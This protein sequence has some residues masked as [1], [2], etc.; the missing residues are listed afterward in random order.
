MLIGVGFANAPVHAQHPIPIT[1]PF[2]LL[3]PDQATHVVVRS[4]NWT[5]A[6]TWSGNAVPNNLAKVLIP[7]GM[8]LV[9]DGEIATRVK[10]LR[11]QGKLAFSTTSNT[12]LRVETILQDVSGELEIGTAMNP[13]PQGITA[14]ITIIDEGDIDFSTDQ[15]EKGMIL[16]GK[17]VAYGA[18]KDSWVAVAANPTMGTTTLSLKSAPSGWEVGDRIV[19]TGTDPRDAKSDEVGVI[20]AVS[21]T[22][23]TL[24]EPLTKNHTAP[25]A[26]LFVHVANLNRNIVIQSE[27]PTSNGGMDRG[28]VMFM[29]T[30]DVDVNY[31]RFSQMGRSRK[32]RPINDWVIGD[33]AEG[34]EYRNGARTNIRGRYSVHFHRG[35]VDQRLTPAKVTGCVVEDDP[36]WAYVNHSAYVHFDNNVSYNVIGGGFQTEAGNEIGSFTNNIAIRTVNDAYPLRLE[37]PDNAPDTREVSQDFAWQGD[38]FWIH[39]GT[40]TVSGNV[41][42]GSS[43]HGFIYWPEGLIEP[44]G[45]HTEPFRTTYVPQDIGLDNSINVIDEEDALQIWW[46]EVENFSNNIAYSAGIGLS[47]YYL[48]TTFF[49]D[50]R[51]YDPAYIASVHSTFQDFTAWNIDQQGIQ[52]NFT[53][54]VTFKNIRL[55]NGGEDANSIGIRA[56]QYR[57]KTRH[58]YDNIHIEGF[59]TGL[60]LPPQGQVTVNGGFLKNGVNLYI[61]S[62]G[63]SFRDMLIHGIRTEPDT[64][65]GNPTEIQMEAFFS[66]PE[67]KFMAYFLL[68][69]K[70]I[71]NYGPY[72]N[73]RLFFDEQ[74]AGYT[75][76]PEDRDPFTLIEDERFILAEFAE[77]TNQQL[78]NQYGMSF[79]GSLLPT[80]AV[81]SPGIIGGKIRA[82]QNETLNVPV[83][84]DFRKETEVEEINLC[85]TDAGSNKIAGPLPAY[86]HPVAVNTSIDNE[87]DLRH[88][89]ELGVPYP[90]PTRGLVS[91]PVP[92][93]EYNVEVFSVHGALVQSFTH[94]GQLLEVDL[95]R[96]ANGMYFIRV[97]TLDRGEVTTLK[98]V[99]LR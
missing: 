9:V 69:D 29:R 65:F 13:V 46:A 75:P 43:G 74:A 96:F 23:V 39:G 11:I 61:P 59:G 44:G 88:S 15:W 1:S 47:M 85:I 57:S 95:S 32:D 3:P 86:D 82:W 5:D 14:Q 98:V 40:I 8:T 26:D 52:L 79:G 12:A 80:D 45:M 10:I 51:D 6:S 48:H 37:E 87:Q 50:I 16:M 55:V 36:G 38:G 60:A 92:L 18:Q 94:M 22:T 30:L 7:A 67:D 76:L 49:N 78:M 25:A 71:L 68:P 70:I 56:N 73:Q 17:T 97:G 24:Q 83:C 66:P 54:R 84:V 89:V 62:P 53:E 19:V 64:R 31:V 91:T 90:N 4:G 81:D 35:G 41:A 27:S 63:L 77:K 33:G 20:Q 21:G 93:A 34:D 2:E 42:S 28:H 72:N 99:K 58:I